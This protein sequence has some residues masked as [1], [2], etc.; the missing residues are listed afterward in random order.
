[1]FSGDH[2][3]GWSTTIVAPPD[4]AMSDYM[5]SLHKL[6]QAQASRS[7]CPAMAARSATRRASSPG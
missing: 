6:A 4:G 3:M 7:T 1:M 2:V 5:N